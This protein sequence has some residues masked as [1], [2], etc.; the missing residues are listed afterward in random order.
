MEKEIGNGWIMAEVRAGDTVLHASARKD[1]MRV[2][3]DGDFS[4]TGY[5]VNPFMPVGIF[6][7]AK[8]AM[9]ACERERY[10][11]NEN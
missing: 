3:K 5:L 6:G 4:Y 9:E 1:N 10:G 7:T 8:E 11:I 2:H